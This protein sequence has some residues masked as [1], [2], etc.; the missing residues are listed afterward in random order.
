MAHALIIAL[1]LVLGFNLGLL[2]IRLFGP[3]EPDERPE[4]VCVHDPVTHLLRSPASHGS[5]PPRERRTSGTSTAS[6]ARRHFPTRA[7]VPRSS[8]HLFWLA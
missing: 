8:A 3:P 7:S 6:S 1:L 4:R 5:L 2:L